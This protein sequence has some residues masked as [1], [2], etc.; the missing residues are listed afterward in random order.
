[1]NAATDIL[2]LFARAAIAEHGQKQGLWRAALA[3][4]WP[5]RRVKA[6]AYGE[7]T[8][9]SHAERM[10][11]AEAYAALLRARIE[12]AKRDMD[13]LAAEASRHGVVLACGDDSGSLRGG[14]DAEDRRQLPL[15]LAPRHRTKTR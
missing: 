4:G 11:A 12:R 7:R 10:R 5:E 1:M 14:S 15:P 9:A 6:A 2:S 8:R 3:V 13:N